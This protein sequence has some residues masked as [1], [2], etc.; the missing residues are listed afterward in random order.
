MKTLFIESKYMG[1]AEL[2]KIKAEKLPKNIGL[3]ATIQFTGQLDK[4]KDYLAD[5][6]KKVYVAKGN[7]KYPGQILGCD[8]SSGEKI[9]SKVD[10]FLY[11]GDGRFHPLGL[12]MS[13]NKEVFCF[14][15]ANGYFSEIDNKEIEEYKKSLKVKKI[16]F[17]S[18]ENVGILVST[19]PGQNNSKKASEIKKK[20]EKEGKK[21]YTFVFD[22]LSLNE[23]ENFP[24][25]DFWVNTACPRIEGDS[26]EVVNV[27]DVE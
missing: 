15:P 21:C 2:D 18:A 14:N 8:A 12:A 4:I 9:K 11:I 3:V 20:L 27:R 26:K 24:F 1:N 6:N 22:T 25:V 5:K 7:Q 17:L 23:L 13:T 19:K 16:R 10:A